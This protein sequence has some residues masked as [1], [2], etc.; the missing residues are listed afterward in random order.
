[1]KV[2][3]LKSEW[4]QGRLVHGFF[5]DFYWYIS[6]H[7]FTSLTEDGGTVAAGTAAAEGTLIL[8]TGTTLND[9]V[10]VGTTNSPFIMAKDKPAVFECSLS[11][12]EANTNTACVA[13]GFG[14]VIN[15]ADFLVDTT[16]VP[17]ATFTGA[18][19]YKISGS[20]VWKCMT[21]V[22]ATQTQTDSVTTSATATL[23]AMRIE[24]QPINATQME[25]TFYVGDVQLRDANNFPIKH[26]V[27]FGSTAMKA[28]AYLKTDS[29]NAEVVTLGYMAA[30]QER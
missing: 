5:E 14:S 23:T 22:G 13:V 25:V 11:Y 24:M 2:L 26:T 16:G 17:A 15:S 20:T 4:A 21:S 30:Y 7:L 19:I 29:T 1:M 8:T 6:P 28:G 12:S 9:E 3:T 18:I 10:A 27:T